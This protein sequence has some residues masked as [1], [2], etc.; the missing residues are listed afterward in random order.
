MFVFSELLKR[1]DEIKASG[2]E[3]G[4]KRPQNRSNEYAPRVWLV[5]VNHRTQ[6]DQASRPQTIPLRSAN[7]S[8]AVFSLFKNV[9]AIRFCSWP[10][11]FCILRSVCIR[12][13]LILA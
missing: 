9:A 5:V 1:R 7:K 3:P 8:R 13:S 10:N 2:A 4:R 11:F 6:L 12:R